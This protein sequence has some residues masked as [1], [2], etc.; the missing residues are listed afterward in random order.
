MA[1][2]QPKVEGTAAN[3]SWEKPWVAGRRGTF[4][5]AGTFAG[6]LIALEYLVGDQWVPF[7]EPGT[8]T[9]VVISDQ[10]GVQFTSPSHR[11]RANI[12]NAA[13]GTVIDMTYTE[14]QGN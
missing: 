10:R 12:T 8:T 7:H 4:A 5:A 2:F 3:D 14:S 11:V 9:P 6:A 13:A 1:K